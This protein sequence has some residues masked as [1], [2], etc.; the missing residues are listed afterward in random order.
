MT[1]ATVVEPQA[2]EQ[3]P[4]NLGARRIPELLA[5]RHEPPVTRDAP[6]SHISAT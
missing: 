3:L 1:D 6:S 4:E 5:E 2:A